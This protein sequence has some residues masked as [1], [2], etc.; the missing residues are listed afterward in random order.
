MPVS[1]VKTIIIGSGISGMS[2]AHFLAK[3]TDDFLLLEAKNK[4]GGILQTVKED[5]FICENGP[6]TLLLN[7]EAI[8]ELVKDCGL[9]ED[10]IY[11][12]K[13]TSQNRYV[14]NHNEIT[15]IPLDI[16]SFIKSPLISAKAKFRM[17]A[18]P[19]FK[20][21]N[22]DVTVLNFITKRFGREFHDKLIEP[23]LTGVYAGDTNKMSAKYT[24]K[25]LWELEQNYGSVLIGLIKRKNKKIKSFNLPNGINELISKVSKNIENNILLNCPVLKIE[26]NK[27]HYKVITNKQIFVC[28]KIISAVPAYA[29]ERFVWDEQL[30]KVLQNVVYNPIDVF[31][32]GLSKK[33]IYNLKK[34][35]GILTKPSDNKN[36][37]GILFSS[38]IFSHVSP[39]DTELYTVLVGG[40]RQ[41]ELCFKE[42]RE[43]NK[44]IFNEL[45]DLINYKGEILYSNN[46]RW[47][48]GIPQYNLDQGMIIKE[49][50]KF[51]SNNQN[52]HITGNFFDGISVSDCVKKAKIKANL[53]YNN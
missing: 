8:I 32:Y 25:L 18:E 17:L 52:F 22:K 11:P 27:N 10:V 43:L 38:Q 15:K 2:S 42:S 5:N 21:H 28:E 41:K 24:L 30:V 36:F 20:K 33:H 16:K 45:K 23:F 7:N 9:W 48:N 6:N 35:F 13:L 29:L 39:H 4:L 31:H 47:T 1:E 3:K 53:I 19:F 34:G 12:S 46:Y 50:N 49:I 51:E 37:L 40:E 26:K 44:I 14:L